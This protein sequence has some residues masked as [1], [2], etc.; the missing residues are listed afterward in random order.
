MDQRELVALLA[1]ERDGFV[2]LARQRVATQTDAEDIVQRA[3]VRAAERAGDV[4]EPARARAWF[5]RLLR[6]AIADHHRGRHVDRARAAGDLADVAYVADDAPA[7]PCAC[8]LRLL[9]ELRP[10][11]AEALRRVDVAGEAPE[12]VARA[13]GIGVG[14]LH[15][16]LFRARR[17]LRDDVRSYCH[18]DSHRPC[19]DCS[20]DASHRCGGS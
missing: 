19:L 4:R 1:P 13:L 18:V 7:R 11:Y 3:L 8:S 2:R 20:C 6:N 12:A 17:A 5:Y 9:A 15:V 16:R 10:A 14:N